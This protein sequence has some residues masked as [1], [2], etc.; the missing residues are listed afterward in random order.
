MLTDAELSSLTVAERAALVARLAAVDGRDIFSAG[1][2]VERRR[3]VYALVAC[4]L[5]LV[6]W[7]VLLAVRL[8]AHYTSGHWNLT[9]VGFDGVLG[10]SLAL[11]AWTAWRRTQLFVLTA[12][13][14]ATLLVCDAWF[15]LTTAAGRGDAMQSLA[16]AVLVELPLAGVLFQVGW[17]LFRDEVHRGRTL[18]GEGDSTLPLWRQSLLRTPTGTG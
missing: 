12:T 10:L 14:T 17:R 7:V 9:W 16:A 1:E 18:A 11:T 6:P 2:A 15:D 5:V 4:C 8:P 3:F 13:A